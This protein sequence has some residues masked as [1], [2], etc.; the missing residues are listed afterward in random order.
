MPKSRRSSNKRSA[1]PER[2]ADCTLRVLPKLQR[3]RGFRLRWSLAG[4]KYARRNIRA[5]AGLARAS[6]HAASALQDRQ[7]ESILSGML[8]H[9]RELTPLSGGY[10]RTSTLK[11]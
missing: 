10:N 1:L 2:E 7:I 4:R 3:T 9:R 11:A 8:W 6:C 5:L